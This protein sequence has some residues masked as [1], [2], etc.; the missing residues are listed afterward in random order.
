MTPITDAEIISVGTELLLGEIVDTN[1]AFLAGE[2]AR[3]G[4]DVYWSVRVGDNADRLGAAL[5]QALE[6]SSLV[7]LTGGL[8]PTDDDMTREAVARAFGEEPATDPDLEQWLRS[9]FAGREQPMPERNLKQAWLIPS[10]VAL[11]NPF[12]TAPGWLARKESG[13]RLRTVVALPG[14]PRELM[15]MWRDQVVPLL[16]FPGRD[17]YRRTFR[18][19]GLGESDI[20][21]LLAGQLSGANPTV[22]TYARRDGV[23]VRV[24]AQADTEEE[25]RTLAAP[26]EQQVRELLGSHIWGVDDEEL[27]NLIMTALNGS[28]RT[29]ATAES[30]SG[31][32]LMQ[33]LSAAPD[34]KTAYRGGVLAW[35]AQ[36]MGILGMPRSAGHWPAAGISAGLMAEAARETFTADWGLAVHADSQ[37]REPD[38]PAGIT[39]VFIALAS[40][41]EPVVRRLALPNP[42][43]AWQRERAT[44]AALQLLWA[45]L[46]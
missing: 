28:G 21:D 39:E 19:T 14:P 31:G 13:G 11:P 46:R 20:A 24:A 9:R 12:G 2:L 22:A 43:A 45:R 27:E 34:A 36:A 18:T 23:H 16:A 26:V 25:A 15:P 4:V 30:L 29:L 41:T 44:V 1:S 7:V 8:G 35:T 37:A 5:E 38:G 40:E 42:D 6:R 17:L 33:V 10:A 32:Q 3:L